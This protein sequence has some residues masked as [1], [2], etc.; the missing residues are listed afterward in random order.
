[1]TPIR[2]ALALA[3]A[4]ALTLILLAPAW[5]APPL[6]QVT[7]GG[8]EIRLGD[9]FPSA[10]ARASTVVASA[11]APGG[12]LTLDAATLLRLARAYGIDWQPLST[13]ERL[14]IVRDEGIA[15]DGR[16]LA[17]PILA[18][19]AARGVDL[20]DIELTLNE[21]DPGLRLPASASLGVER[22]S[23]QPT[24]RTFAAVLKA[25]EGDRLLKRIA[26]TG[27]IRRPLAVPVAARALA[28]GDTISERDLR[29]IEADEARLPRNA[30]VDA[31][32]M[33]GLALKREVKAGQPILAR[34]LAKPIAVEKDAVVTLLVSQPGMQL[35]A[36]GRALADAGL[37]DTVRVVNLKS[38]IVVA[39]VVTAPGTV[40][41][42]ADA[43]AQGVAPSQGAT[44][45]RAPR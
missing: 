6:R 22:L 39:G 17:E 29:W 34:D 24:T 14:V 38:Q 16:F 28:R 13:E 30:V 42:S 27:E 36:R 10:G 9:L 35:T 41:V 26:V 25:S 15:I 40:S 43:P 7:V 44:R 37:G 31:S 2:F 12:H 11:P 45:P 23:Y 18:A 33:L 32:A 1:M 21:A 8:P 20:A 3:S 5:A 4:V 19:L